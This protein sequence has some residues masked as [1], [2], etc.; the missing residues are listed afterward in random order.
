MAVRIVKKQKKQEDK[1]LP[2]LEKLGLAHL[3]EKFPNAQMEA[4]RK[5]DPSL[6][7]DVLQ[8]TFVN[9]W[10]PLLPIWKAVQ[11]GVPAHTQDHRSSHFIKTMA[12]WKKTDT[13]FYQKV[14]ILIEAETFH[15][16]KEKEFFA[17]LAIE[18]CPLEN[19]YVLRIPKNT[20]WKEAIH[21]LWKSKKELSLMFADRL[22][23][24]VEENA[25]ATVYIEKFSEGFGISLENIF[26]APNAKLQV[27]HLLREGIG[28][29]SSKNSAWVVQQKLHLSQNAHVRQGVYSA[30]GKLGKFFHEAVLE[31]GAELEAYGLHVG[32]HS[33][34]DH[35][36]HVLHQG[37]RSRSTLN[38]RVAL[39]DRS[40]EIFRA[41]IHIPQTAVGCVA[42]QDN[43]NLLLGQNSKADSI[44]RLEILTE[45]VEASHGSA[46]GEMDEEELF[47]L[48]SRGLDKAQAQQ[49]LLMGFFENILSLA[50]GNTQEKESFQNPFLHDIWCAIQDRLQMNFER[51]YE[52]E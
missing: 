38:F 5:L 37:S 36:F 40:H 46:S 22:L 50:L 39:L 41:N 48:M 52:E 12:E 43:K 28:G 31:K 49:L 10:E 1:L 42:A 16:P 6:L 4:W 13:I 51:S 25:E 35:D 14:K 47:Y 8:Q 21:I 26:L 18:L 17:A 23:L 29:G 3:Y 33:H 15:W 44:P 34:I 20:A 19:I 11:Q 27:H 32:N 2:I 9:G 30:G 7:L 24:Y 45:E